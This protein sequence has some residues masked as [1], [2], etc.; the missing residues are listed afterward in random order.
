MSKYEFEGRPTIDATVNAPRKASRRQLG[1]VVAEM[2]GAALTFLGG[3]ALGPRW[4]W[5]SSETV[6]EAEQ[7][8]RELRTQLVTAQAQIGS[9]RKAGARD[10]AQAIGQVLA[11]NL[12]GVSLSQAE[13]TASYLATVYSAVGAP[14][15]AL[16][17]H[18]TPR[19][20]VTALDDVLNSPGSAALSPEDTGVLYELRRAMLAVSIPAGESA[21]PTSTVRYLQG[22]GSKIA[23][24]QQGKEEAL[25]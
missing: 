18:V 23:G 15:L 17:A 21:D 10:E 22:L 1:R 19:Q 6:D 7:A 3:A 13:S 4:H 11:G 2:T 12:N 16:F 14:L 25:P 8:T 24:Y 20:I 5:F 9:S